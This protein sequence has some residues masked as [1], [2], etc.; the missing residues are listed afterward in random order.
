M[1]VIAGRFRGVML[2]APPGFGTRPITDRVKESVFNILGHRLGTPGLLPDVPVLDLF[3]GSGSLG[4]ECLSRGAR[5]CV[6]VEHD[7]RALRALRDNLAKLSL[8]SVARVVVENAWTLRIPPAIDRGYGLVFVDP[9]YRDVAE[10]SAA[11]DLLERTP[12]RLS[13]EGLLVFR[14]ARSVR[15]P[16]ES[17]HALERVDERTFGKMRVLLLAKT[18]RKHAGSGGS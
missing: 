11:L 14:L 17:L 9:P 2:A 5:S 7:R 8:T 1:R 3:A 15:F 12:P 10:P 4:I 16:V 18:G 13:D 6:F